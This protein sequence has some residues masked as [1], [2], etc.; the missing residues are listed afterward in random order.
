MESGPGEISIQ[1]KHLKAI[2][3]SVLPPCTEP[4]LE[5]DLPFRAQSIIA[6]PPAYGQAHVAE[7]LGRP[8]CKF[9][10]PFARVPL[11]AGYWL[12]YIL[13]DTDMVEHKGIL[14]YIPQ[15]NISYANRVYVEPLSSAKTNRLGPLVEVVG[16]CFLN[17]GSKYQPQDKSQ[18]NHRHFIGGI[19]GTGQRGIIDRGLGGLG[20]LTEVPDNVFLLEECPHDWLFP[21]CSVVVHHGGAGTTATGLKAGCPTTIVPFFGDQFFWG[22]KVHQKGLGPAPIPIAQLSVESLSNAINFML[23]PEVILMSIF[24]SS[25]AGSHI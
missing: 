22:D 14:Q 15:V 21:Q 3:E 25:P 5:I 19:K 9:P 8:T 16:Y 24:A 20:N 13:V 10:N 12:S 7:A 6:N 18:E 2:I 4:D 17:L 1:R 11:S 23:Q